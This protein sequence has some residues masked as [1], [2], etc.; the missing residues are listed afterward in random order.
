MVR[1]VNAY[2]SAR[3]FGSGTLLD[4]SARHGLV[5]T[6]A[7]LF[8]E[9]VGTVSVVF[10]DGH[11]YGARVLKIDRAWDLA[12]LLIYAPE[13]DPM[14]LADYLPAIGD[15]LSSCGYGEGGRFWC[16]RGRALQ[17]VVASGTASAE[18][19]EISGMARQGDSGGP[20]INARGELAGVVSATNGRVVVGTCCKRIRRFLGGLSNRFRKHQR[21]PNVIAPKQPKLP[22]TPPTQYNDSGV[23]AKI[24]AL[25]EHTEAVDKRSEA[26]AAKL[27]KTLAALTEALRASGKESDKAEKRIGDRIGALVIKLDERDKTAAAA[28][29]QSESRIKKRLDTLKKGIAP[30]ALAKVI[31]PLIPA[32]PAWLKPLVI[33]TPA[34]LGVFL[35][36]YA[37]RVLWRTW[38]RKKKEPRAEVPGNSFQR[39]DIKIPREEQEAV[40]L[41][42][43]SQAEGR[44]PLHDALIGRLAFDELD[45]EIEGGTN[46][47]AEWA[48]ELKSKLEGKFNKIMPLAITP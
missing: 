18:T 3:S 12:A 6:C 16:S 23:L 17:Y 13:A 14:P 15:A 8:R 46:G 27:A 43:L 45:N 44:D 32:A 30:K 2:G 33:G 40:E 31:G 35:L 34:G 20:I 29:V 26:R 9:G 25:N 5:L 28:I 47:R 1:I 36:G 19:L 38:K 7:H 24:S 22:T 4:K 41:L 37:G 39:D 11:K 10:Q 42:R 48:R 21:N